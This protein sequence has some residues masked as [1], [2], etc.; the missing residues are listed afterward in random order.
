MTLELLEKNTGSLIEIQ[1]SKIKDQSYLNCFH[2]I[3]VN[4]Q[5]GK[6]MTLELLEKNSGS[7][8]VI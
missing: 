5:H 2:K 7:L 8:I 1:N 4:E 3:L 6:S